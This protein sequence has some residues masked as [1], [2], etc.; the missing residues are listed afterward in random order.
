MRFD[1]ELQKAK[2][3]L[4]NLYLE[5]WAYLTKHTKFLRSILENLSRVTEKSEDTVHSGLVLGT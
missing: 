3:E 5:V 2:I 1:I 4:Q